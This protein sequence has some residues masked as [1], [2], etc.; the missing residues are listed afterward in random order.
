[1]MR[2]SG[3]GLVFTTHLTHLKPGAH[4]FHIH[5]NPD[6]D[7]TISDGTKMA[8]MAAG[9][10]LDP[11]HSG[12]HMGPEGAGHKGDLPVLT[13]DAKGNSEEVLVAPHLKL[14]DVMEHSI[15]IHEGG[16]NFTDSPANGGG[17]K[18]VACGVI[19]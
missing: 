5:E 2:D 12:K 4:G 10:H 11:A 14:A 17:G 19:Y 15:M 1:M 16:D 7:P 6:C 18:R 3:A 9:G 13:A 8:G